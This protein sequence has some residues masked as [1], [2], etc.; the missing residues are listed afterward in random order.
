M[1]R[2]KKGQFVK[3]QPRNAK[4]QFSND[5]YL[6]ITIPSMYNKHLTVGRILKFTDGPVWIFKEEGMFYT[7]TRKNKKYT[8]YMEHPYTNEGKYVNFEL[9]SEN[10]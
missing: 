10:Y 5:K 4:G 9:V 2:N 3:P 7:L 6:F 1:K 8:L